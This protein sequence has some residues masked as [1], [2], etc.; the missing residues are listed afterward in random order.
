MCFVAFCIGYYAGYNTNGVQFNEF[1]RLE[2]LIDTCEYELKR[3]KHCKLIAVEVINSNG[4][5]NP[6]ILQ[7][8]GIGGFLP[9]NLAKKGKATM[10]F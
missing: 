7:L 4:E 8:S 1:K 6:P 10:I 2:A 3:S 9:I 5:K